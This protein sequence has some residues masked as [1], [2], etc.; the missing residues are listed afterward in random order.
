MIPINAHLERTALLGTEH[1]VQLRTERVACSRLK[2]Q[3]P[4]PVG[5]L[6]RPHRKLIRL[7]VVGSLIGLLEDLVAEIHVEPHEGIRYGHAELRLV[8]L[9]RIALVDVGHLH[10]RIDVLSHRHRANEN[11]EGG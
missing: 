4:A 10:G 2:V 1:E 6:V 7:E 9:G 8:H 3:F 5:I 11:G